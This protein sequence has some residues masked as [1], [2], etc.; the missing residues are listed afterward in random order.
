MASKK[1]AAATKEP[2]KEEIVMKFRDMREEQASLNQKLY[3]FKMDIDEHRVVEDALKVAPGERKCYRLIGGVLVE[4]TVAEVLPAIQANK[5]QIETVVGQLQKQLDT[6][7]K[8][9]MA[10]QAEHKIAIREPGQM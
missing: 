2:T 3:E 4:R 6:K 9:V 5:K 8:E 1:A 7:T 10:Y